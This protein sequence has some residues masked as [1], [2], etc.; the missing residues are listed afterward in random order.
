MASAI[1]SFT[2]RRAICRLTTK[3]YNN[4]FL[5]LLNASKAA[6]AS[7]AGQRVVTEL[8]S[9]D[10]DSRR[11][12][13]DTEFMAGLLDANL[14]NNV[15]RARLRALLTGLENHLRTEKTEDQ[16]PLS[17]RNGLQV[18]HL[19]P[20]RWQEHWPVDF[21][22]HG[23]VAA[24]Q[25]AVHRLG[26]LTLLTQKLNGSISHGAWSKKAGE[27]GK[28]AL[29]LLTTSSVFGTPPNLDQTLASTWKDG[30]DEERILAR[31]VYL[32]SEAVA[33]WPRPDGGAPAVDWRS[34]LVP[35][36]AAV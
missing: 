18:E 36:A 28:H 8:A 1:A 24:R 30:W 3:D 25:D 34:K 22:D 12:P 20:Q 6:P 19:L 5:T 10:A 17:V 16:S 31:S 2:M 33:A 32:A 27:I 11:W 29:L 13:S 35:P 7:H 26:N 23:A 9:M 14:Y 4:L 21:N 15:Y